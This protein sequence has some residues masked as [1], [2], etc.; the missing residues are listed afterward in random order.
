VRFWFARSHWFEARIG[1][2]LIQFSDRQEAPCRHFTKVRLLSGIVTGVAVPGIPVEMTRSHIPLQR[3]PS[4]SCHEMVIRRSFVPEAHMACRLR[5]T[6]QS[7]LSADHAAIYICQAVTARRK[8]FRRS[9][10]P[11]DN[12]LPRRRKHRPRHGRSRSHASGRV[13]HRSGRGSKSHARAAFA[14]RPAPA[15]G[16]QT[17]Q[18][19]VGQT[20]RLPKRLPVQPFD[21][22]SNCPYDLREHANGRCS[23]QSAEI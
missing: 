2:T 20:D 15:A 8:Q 14:M 13:T 17:A 12:R 19:V 1:S 21:P 11:R 9:D 18:A 7:P 22:R 10:A 4:Q 3:G 5:C 6:P 16:R 23:E